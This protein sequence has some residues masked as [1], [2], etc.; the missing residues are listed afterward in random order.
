MVVEQDLNLWPLGLEPD[1]L[2]DY[3]L[4]IMN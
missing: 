1:E 4:T 3:S 2:P